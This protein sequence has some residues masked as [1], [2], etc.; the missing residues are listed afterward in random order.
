TQPEQVTP[1]LHEYLKENGYTTVS[2]GKVSHHPGGM[3]GKDW[4]DPN[5]L[6][7][8]NA[9]DKP[10]PPVAEWEHPRGIMHGLA[11]GHIRKNPADMNV[12]ES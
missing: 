4:N 11:N 7:M 3:G 5:V 9:W 8:P 1:T 2:V 12:Y 10:L 6:E